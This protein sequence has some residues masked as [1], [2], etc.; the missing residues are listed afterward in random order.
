MSTP[1]GAQRSYVNLMPG[2]P[3]PWFNQR[4]TGNARYSFDKAAG[5]Y[6]VLCFYITAEDAAGQAVVAAV[7][8]RRHLFD[9][10]RSAFFGVTIDPADEKTGRVR[11]CQPGIHHFWDF[12]FAISRAYGALPTDS[13]PGEVN[14]T[15][16]RFWLVLDPALRVLKSFFFAS[17]DT[18]ADAVFRY[19]ETLPPVHAP[20]GL[21]MQAPVL[22]VPNVFE[23][24]VCRMLIDTYE[25]NGGIES[26][27][28][29]EIDGK[30]AV[31][32]DP[33]HKRRRDCNLEDVQLIESLKSRVQRRIVPEIA[34]A[35][36]FQ[37]TR[38][39]RFLVACYSADEEGH[40]NPHRDNTTKGTAHRRFAVSLNLNDDYE[41]GELWFPEYGHRT[42]KP[43]PGC[44]VVFSCSLLHAATL[45]TRGR[46]Y[47]FLPF[48]YDEAAAA[49]RLENN[50]YL[51][52]GVG[53][54]RR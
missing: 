22:L 44:A 14:I 12:D 2:D 4:L 28:M 36:Q 9:G 43:P 41:G 45:V 13:A 53:Q 47:V 6:V 31:V 38:M 46:R 51:D 52:P 20:Y 29:R 10:E 16:R 32:H 27:F 3:V 7:E 11:A 48:L 17:D 35:H 15:T 34:K 26:G 19:V 49:L 30:T 5:R 23:P 33:V 8:A 40:F 18:G 50:K 37:V 39:E 1:A 25:A 21:E 54:Y 24:D 42:F